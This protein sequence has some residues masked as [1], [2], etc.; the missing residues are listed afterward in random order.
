MFL[1]GGQSEEEATVNLNALNHLASKGRA[2]PWALSFSFGRAL[3][4]RSEMMLRTVVQVI[5]LQPVCCWCAND[6][7]CSM[8]QASV[9]KV[10][11]EDRQATHEAKAM[12]AALAAANSKATMG[13]YCGPHPSITSGE[14]SLRENF[15]GWRTDVT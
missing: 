2:A 1:S 12:A 5:P 7:I 10:W 6:C 9:L 11:S 15:R 8:A 4:A 13:K 14:Q 3:Q